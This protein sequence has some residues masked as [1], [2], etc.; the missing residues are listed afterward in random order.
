VGRG[1]R[2]SVR[3]VDQL[4]PVA[5]RRLHGP[6]HRVVA[7]R[8]DDL[9][10][11]HVADPGDL[12]HRAVLADALTEAGDPRGELIT[13]QLAIAD[14]RGDPRTVQRAN[15]LLTEHGRHWRGA[16]PGSV[17]VQFKN[18]FAVRVA[19]NAK[20]AE[21]ARA[22]DRPDWV[23]VEELEINGAGA[24]LPRLIARM[25]LLRTLI[26]RR[27]SIE[28]LAGSGAVF[29]SIRALGGGGWVPRDRVAFPNLAVLAG[30]WLTYR[31]RR[32]VDL[33]Q[34]AAALLDLDATV[35]YCMIHVP[36][37]IT[38]VVATRAIGPRE[39]RCV[40]LNTEGIGIDYQGWYVQ[41]WRG[42]DDALV[43]WRSSGWFETET[44][45]RILEPLADVGIRRI[46]LAIPES[47]SQG[48]ELAALRTDIERR[49][50]AITR[51]EPIEIL[52]PATVA[53]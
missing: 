46:A 7:L 24:D 27:E 40:L 6:D 14:G 10:A 42:R 35:H 51:G 37:H 30:R 49:G 26:A 15:E 48:P 38:D 8:L 33:A 41:T 22:I 4:R 53:P 11:R 2:L 19:T 21:L 47:V 1:Q 52:A 28:K 16:F 9:W 32:E 20:G 50:V 3:L 25:P 39:T 34:Q 45:R 13:L 44:A 17:R 29:P 36:G 31:E 18:G 43:G 23:T 5:R 12:A